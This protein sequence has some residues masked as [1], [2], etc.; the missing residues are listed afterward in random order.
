VRDSVLFSNVLVRSHSMLSKTVVLPD[1]Q[2]NRRCSIRNAV[3]DRR[4]KLPEGLVI[5]EDPV[6][7]AQRF[8]RSPGGV[9]LVTRDMLARLAKS[10]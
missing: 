7:D 4:C 1:V 5:G 6:A 3:I 2:I 8:Y 9:V 10:A